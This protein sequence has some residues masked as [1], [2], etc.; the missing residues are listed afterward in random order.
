[1]ASSLLIYSR[2]DET[3][4]E[5]LKSAFYEVMYKYQKAFGEEGVDANLNAWAQAKEPLL[6]LLRQHPN[7]DEGA[8]AV[9][10]EFQEGRG[11]EPD[12]VDEIAFDLCGLAAELLEPGAQEGFLTAIQAA[13]HAYS[14]TLPEETLE[15]IRRSGD[16]KCAAG[17]K[18]S[19][20]IGKLCRRYGVDKHDRYNTVFAQLSDALNPLQIQKTAVLS[21]HPCDFLEMSSKDNTWTSCHNIADGGYQGGTLSYLADSV[22]MIFFTVDP[23]VTDHFYRAPRRTRQM[24]FYKDNC[25]YQSRLYPNG[26]ADIME[27]NRRVVHKIISRCL[28]VPNLWI[29]KSKRDEAAQCCRSAEGSVQYPDYDYYGNLSLI[30]GTQ[31]IPQMEV[32]RAPICVCCGEKYHG[33][34][35]LKC[36]CA[37][38]VVC[39]DCGRTVPIT[40][41]RYVDGA[42]HCNGCLH[43]CAAC[44]QIVRDT[45]YPA[46]D[47]KGRPVEVCLSCFTAALEPC[48]A[49]SVQ[50]VCRIIGN[51]LC[52]RT[53]IRQAV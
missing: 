12:S 26:D 38:T 50:G 32:G 9:V 22:S 3:N 21:V 29:L 23:E 5:E 7:W 19:R 20:I 18:T 46:F 30:K 53:A 16:I 39:Q 42:Y 10:L 17:Q 15:I 33:R 24:F 49:C 14:S 37:D 36:R 13:V 25:L 31:E 6:S 35:S 45:M 1:M 48:A 8:K 34:S 11:I 51:S 47:R 2:K 40:Q 27:Q 43:I 44:G 52:Q 41:A 4:M 28:S